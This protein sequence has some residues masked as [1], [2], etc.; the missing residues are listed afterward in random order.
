MNYMEKF[1]KYNAELKKKQIAKQQQ[2]KR[3]VLLIKRVI[4]FKKR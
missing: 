2:N 4:Y 1:Q 3:P